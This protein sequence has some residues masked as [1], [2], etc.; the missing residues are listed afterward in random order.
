MSDGMR[1][2]SHTIQ[3]VPVEEFIWWE[4]K[5]YRGMSSIP[6]IPKTKQKYPAQQYHLATE[7]WSLIPGTK[8]T[9]LQ[10]THN[11]RILTPKKELEKIPW[12]TKT[13]ILWGQQ[14]M[15]IEVTPKHMWYI[16]LR[17]PPER[18]EMECEQKQGIKDDFNI[19]STTTR[20]T[21]GATVFSL[22][23][24]N[25]WTLKYPSKSYKGVTKCK[26]LEFKKRSN[27]K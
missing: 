20:K 18:L 21:A 23:I 7:R 10:G 3:Q 11:W 15:L 12:Y 5:S 22:L 26:S 2:W 17:S 19:L 1:I 6:S 25:A 9:Y 24:F 13:F 4:K 16:K 14:W 27:Q 8:D